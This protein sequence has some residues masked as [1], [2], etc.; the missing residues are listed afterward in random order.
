MSSHVFLLSS[1]TWKNENPATS[2]I[3]KLMNEEICKRLLEFLRKFNNPTYCPEF[4]P[5]QYFGHCDDEETQT[6]RDWAILGTLGPNIFIVP[7]ISS[8]YDGRGCDVNIHIYAID[9]DH[10]FAPINTRFQ[11]QFSME[12]S[13]SLKILENRIKEQIQSWMNSGYYS[14]TYTAIDKVKTGDYTIKL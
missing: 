12:I 2:G 8:G 10:F 7:Q 4:E 14:L 9:V 1:G 3:P 11:E 6:Q 13:G 5:R